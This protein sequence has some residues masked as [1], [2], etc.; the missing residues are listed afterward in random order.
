[1]GTGTKNGVHKHTLASQLKQTFKNFKDVEF[2]EEVL[3]EDMSIVLD[4]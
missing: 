3:L 2:E 1:M 4:Q